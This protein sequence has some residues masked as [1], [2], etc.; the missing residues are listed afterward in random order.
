MRG[1]ILAHY[2]RTVVVII[3]NIVV[4]IIVIIIIIKFM[5]LGER[6]ERQQTVTRRQTL[7]GRSRGRSQPFKVAIKQTKECE[8][9][10]KRS[11][12]LFETLCVRALNNNNNL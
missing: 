2:K 9:Y 12:Y 7:D 8:Q 5:K 3:I 11:W 4:I 10:Q 1:A 6:Q